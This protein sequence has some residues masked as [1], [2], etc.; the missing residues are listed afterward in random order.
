MGRPISNPFLHFQE[1]EQIVKQT[2]KYFLN[3]SPQRGELP[4]YGANSCAGATGTAYATVALVPNE[5]HIGNVLITLTG[6]S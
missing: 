5:Q 3:K 6:L 1:V 4:R 2:K